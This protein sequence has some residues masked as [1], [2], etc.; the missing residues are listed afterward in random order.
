[1]AKFI[2]NADPLHKNINEQQRYEVIQD[3]PVKMITSAP[4]HQNLRSPQAM[5]GMSE[6]MKKAGTGNIFDGKEK[7]QLNVFTEV[8]NGHV[9]VKSIEVQDGNHRLAAGLYAGKW[10]SI[11]DIPPA[12]LDIEVNGWDTHGQQHPRWI[13]L[14]VAQ[15]SGIPKDQWF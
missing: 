11:K 2:P 14:Q 8:V 4:G 6:S 15:Q 12:Y 5:V 3:F 10:N 7:I 9:K 13:P 1:F